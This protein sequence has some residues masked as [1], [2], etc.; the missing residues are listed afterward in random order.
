[1]KAC[2]GD[3][4]AATG[5]NFDNTHNICAAIK[6]TDFFEHTGQRSWCQNGRCE[7]SWCICKWAMQE[8]ASRTG[9]CPTVDCG[10][11]DVCNIRKSTTDAGI[12][13]RA[14]RDCVR[15]SCPKEWQSCP[16]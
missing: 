4:R 12:E 15:T 10:A 1:M 13:L 8:W 7:P 14:A 16:S 2:S 11:T 3:A 5:C 6:G 9:S